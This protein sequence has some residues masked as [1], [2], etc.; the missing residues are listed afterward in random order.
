MILRINAYVNLLYQRK[1]FFGYTILAFVL[2]LFLS[3]MNRINIALSKV[4]LLLPTY[5]KLLINVTANEVSLCG[6]QL[7]LCSLL[8]ILE[9]SLVYETAF[10]DE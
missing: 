2:L 10:Y 4:L 6:L 1:V 5:I 8:N 3:S 7:R 9:K